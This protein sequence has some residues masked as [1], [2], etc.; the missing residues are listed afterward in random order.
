MV[1]DD[2][3]AV[4]H[5]GPP[6]HV[7]PGGPSRP[8]NRH[9]R[10][11][12]ASGGPVAGARRRAVS[13]RHSHANRS[14]TVSRHSHPRGYGAG[15][16]RHTQRDTHTHTGRQPDAEPDS[17]TQRH[18]GAHQRR[19]L[20]NPKGT[21]DTVDPDPVVEGP[22]TAPARTDGGEA[23]ARAGKRPHR[24][25]SHDPRVR[26]EPRPDLMNGAACGPHAEL[27]LRTIELHPNGL[28]RQYA[29]QQAKAVCH[30]CPVRRMC[31]DWALG[32]YG[33]QYGV[34]GGLDAD[35]RVQLI[36]ERQP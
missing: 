4:V 1:R 24:G 20:H 29:V 33:E 7:C 5:P 14:P 22:V 23:S 12:T 31:L 30:T 36:R 6:C 27:F 3:G 8:A 15:A 34:L 10:T 11:R 2:G 18:T 26:R 32:I 25:P 17:H 9:S 21:G 19:T 16:H 13:G 35:E 28:A